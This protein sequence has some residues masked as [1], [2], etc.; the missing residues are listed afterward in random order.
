MKTF[1]RLF[2]LA[3]FSGLVFLNTT[4]SKSGA[5]TYVTWEGYVHD[6]SLGKPIIGLSVALEGCNSHTG[7]NHVQECWQQYT[8]GSTTTDASGHFRIYGKAATFGY[9]PSIVEPNGSLWGPST[10]VGESDLKTSQ[11]TDIHFHR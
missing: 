11:Y 4:C 8:V 10:D 1:K 6:D 5:S 2:I 3:I 9:L 7:E